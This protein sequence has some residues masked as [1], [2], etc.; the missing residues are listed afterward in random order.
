MTSQYHPSS[1]AAMIMVLLGIMIA[2]SCSAAAWMVPPAALVSR[3]RM[4]TSSSTQRY[5]FDW[6]N[7]P[8]PEDKSD[9]KKGPDVTNIFTNMFNQMSPPTQ[10]E[11]KTSE[12]KEEEVQASSSSEAPIISDIEEAVDAIFPPETDAVVASN[13]PVVAEPNLSTTTIEATHDIYVGKVNWFNPKKGFGF[14]TPANGGKDIFV[15]QSEIQAP[16][17]RFLYER[18]LVEYGVVPDAKGLRAIHVTGPA[19][20]NLRIVQRRQDENAGAAKD[21]EE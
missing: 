17:Y 12:E 1:L 14:I 19:G 5:M 6:L 10:A 2:Q 18:E 11:P 4:T 13:E 9:D 20:G 3:P 16:G 7:K 15:H 21:T 8:K